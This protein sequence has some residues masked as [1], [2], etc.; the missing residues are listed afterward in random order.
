MRYEFFACREHSPDSLPDV[1]IGQARGAI[2]QGNFTHAESCL[3]RANRADI[4][5]RYYKENE[6][7]QDAIR[8]ARDY[9][10]SALP[11]LEVSHLISSS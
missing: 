10:P 2:E 11:E 3:L 6:M 9:A 4:I 1:Y 8:I 5:L 7:W